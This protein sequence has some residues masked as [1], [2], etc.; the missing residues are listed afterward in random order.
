MLYTSVASAQGVPAGTNANASFTV[1]PTPEKVTG[2]GTSF[3]NTA[4]CT[5]EI[6]YTSN[7]RPVSTNSVARPH[8]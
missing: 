3:T 7:S 8:L 5:L 2:S 6:R 4:G 1:M